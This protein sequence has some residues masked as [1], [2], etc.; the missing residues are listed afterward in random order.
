MPRRIPNSG[1]WLLIS[2]PPDIRFIGT[3][4]NRMRVIFKEW[5][6][7]ESTD[8]D[9]FIMAVGEAVTNSLKHSDSCRKNTPV[10][11]IVRYLRNLSRITADVSDIGPGFDPTTL[12]HVLQ[13]PSEHGM[14]RYMMEAGAKVKYCWRNN[15]FH[16]ILVKRLTTFQK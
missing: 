4:R 6:I 3:T 9:M 8:L 5:G 11:V 15:W 7:S 14:G 12:L 1:D 16:C 13:P 2:F 10:K